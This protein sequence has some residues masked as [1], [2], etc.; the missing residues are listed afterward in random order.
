MLEELVILMCNSDDLGSKQRIVERR[1]SGK[2]RAFT[3]SLVPGERFRYLSIVTS[4]GL[5]LSSAR[6][7]LDRTVNMAEAKSLH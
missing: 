6:Q 4:G 5:S 2:S 1:Q 7:R 3:P